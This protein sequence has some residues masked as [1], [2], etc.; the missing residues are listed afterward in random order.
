MI[1]VTARQNESID[2][3]LKKFNAAVAADGILKELKE[4]SHYEKPSEKKRRKRIERLKEGKNFV[5]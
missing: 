5:K 4:R 3:L 1:K 2:S